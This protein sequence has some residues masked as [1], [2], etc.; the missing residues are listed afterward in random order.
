MAGESKDIF[1]LD[2]ICRA[3]TEYDAPLADKFRALSEN[4]AGY[5][6]TIVAFSGGVDS[7]LLAYLTSQ[8]VPKCLI[9]TSDS[10]TLPRKEL[11]EAISFATTYNLNHRIVSY[12]ELT[13][14]RFVKNDD[15]R[16]FYCKDGLFSLLN[17][18]REKEGYDCIFDGSNFDD[19]DD[20]RPGRE[21]AKKNKIR[22]PLLESGM[23]KEDI[24]K[25]SKA[26][27][28][29][30]WDKP[31]MACLSSRFPRNMEISEEDL[32]RVEEA[33]EV[34]KA[35]GYKDVRVRFHGDIARIELGG[36]EEVDI[37]TLKKVVPKIKAL[38]FRFAT[39]DLEGY[40]MGS[41]ND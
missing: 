11:S 6:S 30:T 8:L 35:L 20:Y 26:L 33:E 9:V 25:V 19:L 27:G 22:S 4:I 29:P 7:A 15:K 12:N 17:D 13:D 24:R 40:R 37:E 31:Q 38:G 41:L 32:K 34:V 3:L 23:G 14:E 10:P 1:D 21:A 39:L 28:L 16:C 18:I 36:E 2:D 5:D